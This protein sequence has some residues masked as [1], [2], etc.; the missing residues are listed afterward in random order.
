M[1]A[2]NCCFASSP[3][4]SAQVGEG[5]R[6]LLVVVL[7]MH[8]CGTST[9][10]RGLQVLGVDL[11]N[12]LMPPM[13]HV[14]EKGFW[15]DIDINQLN[16]EILQALDTDWHYLSPLKRNFV[17]TLRKKG[18]LLRA[19]D[20]LRR[21]VGDAR[22]FGF[23]DPRVTQLLPFWIEV[24]AHCEFDLGYVLAIRNPISVARSLQHRDQFELGKSVLMWLRYTVAIFEE[25]VARKNRVVV[26]YDRLMQGPERELTRIG[27]ALGLEVN[28]QRMSAYRSEFIDE[29]LQHSVYRPD[30][31]SLDEYT[32]L[33]GD[34]YPLLLAAACDEIEIDA[35]EL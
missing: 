10:T 35:P 8:R 17:D 27:S 7:G 20:L 4:S 19:V 31:L 26:D 28:S 33:A 11:G 23:K 29:R 25:T 32:A 14:N 18:F 5:M 6:P 22:C 12:R 34:I 16:V 9:L 3:R 1:N 24:F 13:E 30:Y 15:E 21:K 2:R